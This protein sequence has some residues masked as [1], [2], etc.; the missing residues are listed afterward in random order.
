MSTRFEQL[1]ARRLM[2]QAQCAAQRAEIVGIQ[3]EID[4][5]A[6]RVDRVVA[7]VRRLGPLFLAAGVVATIAIGPRRLLGVARPTLTFAL[8]ASRAARFLR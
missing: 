8:L 2:L 5:G 1:T 4:A 3:A 7:V 6:A